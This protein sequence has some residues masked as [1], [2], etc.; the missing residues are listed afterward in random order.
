MPSFYLTSIIFSIKIQ[1]KNLNFCKS[2][3]SQ[4]ISRP[5]HLRGRSTGNNYAQAQR[6]CIVAYTQYMGIGRVHPLCVSP[7]HTHTH[8][9]TLT[10]GDNWRRN[11]RRPSEIIYTG[12]FPKFNDG[13]GWSFVCGFQVLATLAL[14][15]GTLS[16]GLA[17]GYTSPA[18]DSIL[19]SQV[20]QL[21]QSTG[22]STRYNSE[23]TSKQ[24]PSITS[25]NYLF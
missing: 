3:N 2:N 15:M 25:K 9:H 7:K 6:V 13:K 10:Q 16:S 5:N 22:N 8:T 12:G 4:P 23:Q 19:D 17:K 24:N 21:Y 20:P 1:Q 14:S 18:L 11:S